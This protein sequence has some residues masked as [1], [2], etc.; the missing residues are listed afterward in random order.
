[1]QITKVRNSVFIVLLSFL[2]HASINA[3][4]WT[5]VASGVTTPLNSIFL[6]SP[7]IIYTAGNLGVGLKTI[8]AGNSW[9]QMSV[10]V[11]YHYAIRFINPTTGYIAGANLGILKTTD[12]GA[13]WNYISGGSPDLYDCYFTDSLSGWG[14]GAPEMGFGA[15]FNPFSTV[16]IQINAVAGKALF[17]TWFTNHS[18]GWAVG[19]YGTI[20]RTVNGGTTWLPQASNSAEHLAKIM[21]IN[22]STAIT[23]GTVGTI[24]KTTDGGLNWIAMNSG[25]TENLYSIYY[26]DIANVWVCGDNGTIL[27][28]VDGGQSWNPESS[29]TSVTLKSIHGIGTSDV[30]ACGLAGV[31]IRRTNIASVQDISS[32]SNFTLYPNPAGQFVNMLFDNPKSEKHILN[33]YN[34]RGELVRKLNVTNTNSIQ[35]KRE[36]LGAGI[37][38]F[39]LYNNNKIVESGKIHF[40]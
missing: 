21:F 10:G 25:T 26:A 8:N 23:V 17:G 7:D 18:N 19:S 29:G 13:S 9:N 32:H 24:L 6:V 27:H 15:L 22:A 38:F 14:V 37:Y 20:V 11:A 12:A 34:D 3:Q 5:Q 1:M 40:E 36:N 2:F 33:L 31:L 35:I 30:W 39:Q 28:S 16:F 4:I